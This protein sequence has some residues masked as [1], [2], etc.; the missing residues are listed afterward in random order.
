MLSVGCEHG[1]RM[2]FPADEPE[3]VQNSTPEGHLIP[4]RAVYD[5]S[6]PAL[7]AL[8]PQG[9]RLLDAPIRG[10]C[11]NDDSAMSLP[12]KR[13]RRHAGSVQLSRQPGQ[14]PREDCGREHPIVLTV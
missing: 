8:I 2:A 14:S 3:S 13:H 6:A 4:A 10:T 5:F 12:R 7:D 9:A 1:Y 11:S